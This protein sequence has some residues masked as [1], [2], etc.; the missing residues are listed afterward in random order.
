MVE[1]YVEQLAAT[2]TRLDALACHDVPIPLPPRA[3]DAA[4]THIAPGVHA[5]RRA[6]ALPPPADAPIQAA[7]AIIE[8]RAAIAL[9]EEWEG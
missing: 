6:L 2:L 3:D 8:L 5:G 9:L 4:L 1:P 7:R